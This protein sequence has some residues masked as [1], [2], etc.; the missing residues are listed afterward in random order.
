MSRHCYGKGGELMNQATAFGHLASTPSGSYAPAAW[1]LPVKAG[2]MSSRN[3]VSGSGDVIPFTLIEG[4][5]L[6]SAI[7]GEGGAAGSGQLIISMVSAL[8][9]SGA[10]TGSVRGFLNLAADLA[11]HGDIAGAITALAHAEASAT[12]S[13]NLAATIAALGELASAINVTGATL[14]TAN[15]G[16]AVWAKIIESGYSAEEII[17]LLTAALAGKT[18]GAGT[19]SMQF[20]DLSDTKD[21][22]SGTLD[23][24]GNRTAVTLDGS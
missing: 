6:I 12:G 2:G 11:G 10:I 16:D 9:G 1:I 15:V 13:G 14:T 7:V 23:S 3:M 19:T 24:S 22:I 8:S 21:R 18:T 4:R 17:R 5:N 20:R